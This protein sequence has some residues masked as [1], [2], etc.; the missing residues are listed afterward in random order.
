MTINSVSRTALFLRKY[1]GGVDAVVN[2]SMT[3]GNIFWVHHSGSAT[4]G[5][6]PA[7][8]ITTLDAAVNLC[9]ANQ[10]DVIFLMPGH[11]E[12]VS[13]A[14]GCVIDVTGVKIIGLGQGYERPTLT[15]DTANTATI[16]INAQSVWMENVLI[17]SNFLSVAKAI[18]VGTAGDGLTLKNIEM[19]NVSV[20]LGAMKQISIATTVDNVTIDGLLV[21]EYATMTT[22]ATNVIICDGTHDGFTLKN[23]RIYCFTTAAAVALSA[24]IGL[25]ITLENIRLAQAETSAGLGI[26]CHNSST[27]FAEDITV[28]NLKN[29]VKG[30]TGTGLSIGARVN[31]SNAV[32]AYAGLFSY[33]IDS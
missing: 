6:S 14:T 5:Y 10:G 18:T 19:K 20:I 30:L 23:S 31:Y 2:E 28:V 25:G 32:N 22:P 12:S 11:A 21:R 24:G 13:S 27:G 17:I 9:T 16:S 29:T 1:P 3:T 26:A 33:T 4:G 8:P 15:L 7:A